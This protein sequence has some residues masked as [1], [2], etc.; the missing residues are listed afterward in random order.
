MDFDF[1]FEQRLLGESVGRMLAGFPAATDHPFPYPASDVT[2][3]AADLGLFA[4]DDGV[5]ILGAV[6][7]VAAALEIGRA[8]PAAPLTE[9]LAA[10]LA[11]AGSPAIADV[12]CAGE[13]VGVAVTGAVAPDGG[14]ALVPFAHEARLFVLPVAAGGHRTWHVVNRSEVTLDAADLFDVASSAAWV[15]LSAKPAD[16]SAA[17]VAGRLDDLLALLVLAEMTGAA[18]YALDLT[19]GYA[20]E[21]RQFGRPIGQ[22]QAIK[23]MAADAAVAVETMKAAVEYAAWCIDTA[24][25]ELDE[26]AGEARL[27]LLSTRSHV[28]GHARRVAEACVQMHGGI[29]FTWDYGLHRTLKRIVTRQT[30]LAA[31]RASREALADVLMAAADA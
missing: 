25:E 29:A 17:S 22:N 12:L 11:L 7:A 6:D 23:H 20:K 4:S 13:P 3:A 30:T 24:P 9:M 27:A 14:R 18:A 8:L 19:V 1:S 15:S 28:G 26:P 5:P 21:R 2:R 10:S 31:P 16:H